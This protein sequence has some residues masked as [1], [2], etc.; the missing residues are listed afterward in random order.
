MS[1]A[2]LPDASN[3][4]APLRRKDVI[5]R[6]HPRAK[7]YLAKVD[8]EGNILLTVPRAG[9]QRDALAFANCHREWLLG[10]QDKA[11]AALRDP[12]RSRGLRDGDLIWL[13]G[14]R[15][16]LRIE[17]DLGRPALCFAEHRV[18]IADAEMDLSRPLKAYLKALAKSELPELVITAANR[19][20]LKVKK[21]LVR[22]QK[23]RWGSYST[24]GTLSLNWRLLLA[25]EETRDY[26][27]IHEL[28]HMKRFDHSPE[29]WALV[30]AACPSYRE[31]EA[32][33]RTHQS[34][35]SW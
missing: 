17:K 25:S 11:R 1:N 10:E 30:E 33:L 19:F 6:A 16:S 14:Q 35:L 4:P 7:R 2:R 24:S 15:V 5:F 26:V 21:V 9:T 29:F 13:R 22:D 31:H 18:Y 32:W 12:R 20:G 3:E 27:I 34:E 8:K 28:M 23:T